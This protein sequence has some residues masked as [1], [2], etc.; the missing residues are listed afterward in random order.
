MCVELA[1]AGQETT[2]DDGIE[3]GRAEQLRKGIERVQSAIMLKHLCLR[4][5]FVLGF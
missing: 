1:H 4:S 2:T 3:D 5:V